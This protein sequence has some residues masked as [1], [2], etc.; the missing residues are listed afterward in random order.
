MG[1]L[2]AYIYRYD[3]CI[4]LM[5]NRMWTSLSSMQRRTEKW[6]KRISIG[7]YWAVWVT[8]IKRND[9]PSIWM[10]HREPFASNASIRIIYYIPIAFA[11]C[12]APTNDVGCFLWLLPVFIITWNY[13]RCNSV[14]THT[15]AR[16]MT[17]SQ[18]TTHFT[19]G[20]LTFWATNANQFQHNESQWHNRS[21]VW[22]TERRRKRREAYRRG[23]MRTE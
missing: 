3:L 15:Q 18:R 23:R 12:F 10:F 4:Y 6:T 21:K 20:A 13:W 16:T 17:H 22:Q 9:F 5:I 1:H 7:I 14:H 8:L 11:M 2:L 19:F